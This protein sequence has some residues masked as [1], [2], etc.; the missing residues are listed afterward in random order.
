MAQGIYKSGEIIKLTYQAIGGL[1]AAAPVCKIYDEGNA[2]DTAKQ[3]VLKSALAANEKAGGRYLGYFTPDAEGKWTVCIQ[4]KNGDGLVSKTYEVCGHNIDA[5][6]DAVSDAKSAAVV[7]GGKATSALNAA[8]SANA[9]A[10]VAS[11]KATSALGKATSALAQ[12]AAA[13]GYA[14][15]AAT[16]DEISDAKSAAV[17]A[18]NAATSALGKANSALGKAASALGKATSAAGYAASANNYASAA[19]AGASPAMVS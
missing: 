2:S 19:A 10:A 8:T 7:A 16:D 6:G 11:G 13:A 14:A 5:V 17:V 3:S 18:G 1:A 12:A 9:A 4:D 15:T